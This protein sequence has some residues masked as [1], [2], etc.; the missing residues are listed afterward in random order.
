MYLKALEINPLYVMPRCNLAMYLLSEEKVEE[1]EDM[2]AP[3]V[4]VSQLNPQEMAFLSYIRARIHI[5]HREYDQVRNILEVAMQVYPEYELAKDLLERLATI[6]L[7][8]KGWERFFEKQHQRHLSLRERQ[9]SRLTTSDPELT[10]ALGIYSK[11]VLVAIARQ[12]IPWG[13]GWSSFKKAELHQYLVDF[14][15]EE[16]SLDR[17]LESLSHEERTAFELVQA[18]GGTLDWETFNQKFGNDLEESPYWQYHEPKSVLGR[19]RAH[20]LLFEVKVEGK[21]LVSIPI[22][23]RK[24]MR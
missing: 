4:D 8:N 10:H 21:L 1:A 11:E 9:R 20:A 15:L 24:Q 14:L 17:V 6:E 12:I 7:M 16:G 13:G 3:L 18:N 5:E 19:L 23:L 22:E 2:I